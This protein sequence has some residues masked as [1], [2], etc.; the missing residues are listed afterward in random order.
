MNT[1]TPRQLALCAGWSLL[2]MAALAGFAY[3]FGFNQIYI[4][5]DEL[6]TV[7]Q[8]TA[9]ES[10]FRWLFLAFIGILV[11]DIL[12][13]WALYYFLKPWHAAL[14]LLTACFRIMYTALL[15][16][17][18]APLAFLLSSLPAVAA[19]G[20]IVLYCFQAF[21][22]IWSMALLVFGIHLGLLAY[23]LF[24]YTPLPKTGAALLLLAGLAYIAA[25]GLPIIWPGYA[26]YRLTLE[27][28]LSLPMAL[29]ELAL[30]L[31]LIVK[32]GKSKKAI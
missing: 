10:L 26:A 15:G 24:R 31:W 32:G 1:A 7:Q 30:A 8:L 29:G 21:T 11:L 3:G 14:S 28:L 9:H 4:A 6:A 18:L 13:S 20:T 19:K 12:V 2:L 22:A 16:V 5:H 25:H 17:A 23:L 27:A